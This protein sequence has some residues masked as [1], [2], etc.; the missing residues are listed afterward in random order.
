MKCPF[1]WMKKFCERLLTKRVKKVPDPL[2]MY[3]SNLQEERRKKNRKKR[4]R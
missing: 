3:V 4:F 2:A 1:G